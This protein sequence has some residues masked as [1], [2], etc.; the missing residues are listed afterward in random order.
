MNFSSFSPAIAARSSPTGSFLTPVWGP[1]H[2]DDV[3]YLRVYV[4]QLHRKLGDDA[5]ALLRTEPNIGY[6]LAMA[7]ENVPH[8]A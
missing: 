5:G 7:S 4:R 8:E 2:T 6:R 1:A 3:Q